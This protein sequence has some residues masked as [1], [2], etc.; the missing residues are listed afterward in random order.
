M[1]KQAKVCTFYARADPRR[2]FS[3]VSGSATKMPQDTVDDVNIESKRHIR[4][5][6]A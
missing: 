6:V 2:K 4:H 3:V 5:A 1:A